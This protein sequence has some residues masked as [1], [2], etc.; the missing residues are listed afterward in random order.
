MRLLL[1]LTLASLPAATIAGCPKPGEMPKRVIFADG[2]VE[3]DLQITDGVLETLNIDADGSESR[4]TA[5]YGR[6]HTSLTGQAEIAWTWPT[7]DLP[8]AEQLPVDKEVSFDAVVE[9]IGADQKFQMRYSFTSHGPD[10]LAVGECSVPVIWLDERQD[11]SDGS[12]SI[13]SQIWVDPERM[14]VLKTERDKLD[15]S[16]TIV[17]HKAALA[18]GFEM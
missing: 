6:Y 14:L 7:L 17:A 9:D 1:C 13:V 2:S 15:E 8:P 18:T 16:G 4:L 12:G 3:E 5:K 10:V 11:F